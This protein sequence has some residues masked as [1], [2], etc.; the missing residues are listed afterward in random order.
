M[1]NRFDQQ[2]P[3]A[4]WQAVPPIDPDRLQFYVRRARQ[5]RA[6]AFAEGLKLTARAL[7]RAFGAVVRFIRY[8]GHGIAKRPERTYPITTPSRLTR[9]RG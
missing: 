4:D 9:D 6:E 2:F 1:S 8:A 5:L 3:G 7:A